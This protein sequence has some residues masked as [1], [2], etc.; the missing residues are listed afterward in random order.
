MKSIFKKI[1]VAIIT[2]EAKLVLNKYKPKIVAVTGSVGKTST[3]DAIFTVLSGSRHV[4]RSEKSFNSD[5][6]V[7]LTILGCQ[8]AWNNPIAWLENIYFGFSLVITKDITY[9]K[10]L[11]LE[12]GADRPG[13]IQSIAKWLKPDVAVVTRFAKIPVHVEYFNSRDDLVREKRYLVEALRRDSVAVL[14]YDDLEVRGFSEFTE[15]K[16]IFYGFD[17]GDV[18]ASH[19]QILIET[20]GKG[21]MPTGVSFDVTYKEEKTTIQL[22][23]G[24]G[25]QHVYPALAAIAVGVSQGLSLSEMTHALKSHQSPKGRMHLIEGIKGSMLIDDTY[26]SSPIAVE[27]ALETLKNLP[28][29]SRKIAILGDMMELGTLSSDAHRDIGTKV[30]KTCDILVTVGIRSRKTADAALDA[31]LSEK[32]VYQF[33]DSKEAGAFIQN[34]VGEGDV[35]LLKGSQSMR[36]ERAVKELMAHPEQSVDLIVR[37]EEEWMKR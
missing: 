9:P 21:T 18:I 10:W 19:Y 2:W 23:G 14:N 11:V 25:K 34:L 26:N 13:D 8:N 22:F 1:I 7:P 5:I 17:G 37:Q 32:N 27:E 24:L 16:K 6:G 30:A 29:V 31:G 33:D 3:K 28:N 35:I 36:M 4:R 12:V 20:T 15:N